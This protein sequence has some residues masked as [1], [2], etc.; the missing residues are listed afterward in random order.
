MIRLPRSLAFR[1]AIGYGGLVVGAMVAMAAVLYIGTVGVIERGIEIKLRAVSD[2]LA[3]KFAGGG[4]DG[5]QREIQRALADNEDQDTEVYALLDRSGER[6]AGN[7]S[8]LGQRVPD[9]LSDLAVTR[10]G[11]PSL[12]RLLPR[13]LSNG[14]TLIV[15]WDLA[16]LRAIKQLV[17]NSLL[18]SVA[19]ALLLAIGG[20]ILFRRQLER[21]IAAIRRTATEIAAGD[22]TRRI[23]E[24]GGEDEFT[25]LNL[26][27]N[28]MLDRIERLMNGVRDVS[29]AIAHDL[30]TPLQRIR[31]LL[32]EALSS[33]MPIEDL[34][35]RA[36]AAIGAIDDLTGLLDKLLQIAEAEAGSRR[37]SFRPVALPDVVTDVVE[38]YDAAAEASGLTIAAEV[39]GDA[40]A[41]GDKDLLAAATANLVD[42]AL[43]YAG[44]GATIRVRAGHDRGMV[45]VV[46]QDD[47]PGIPQSEREKV[48][49]R[50]YRL[51][52]SRSLPG[53]GLGLAIVNAIAELHGGSLRLEDA[54]PGLV[55]R[56]VL[57]HFDSADFPNGNVTAT[58]RKVSLH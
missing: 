11:R 33:H 5:L 51:D 7:I 13:K 26:S 10:Y 3:N 36:R 50:F 14:D 35:E 17:L 48:V 12:S 55:A 45:S 52:R 9:G 21:R 29:N 23:P 30:R 20:A 24:L 58:A 19:L 56:I 57:P 15:G 6:I 1:L 2:Q 47:G 40:V 28:H 16:D 53:N 44:E 41:F 38:L 25:R 49:T 22:L 8:D 46:V 34:A 42:N 31:G 18:V 4:I 32:D 27:V 39:A 37:R 43:K 54:A